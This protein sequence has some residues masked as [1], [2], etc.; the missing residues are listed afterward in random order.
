MKEPERHKDDKSRGGRCSTDCSDRDFVGMHG[1]LID[2]F[3]TLQYG[4]ITPELR[5][6][7]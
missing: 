2:V 3:M 4:F 5:R 7:F 6:Y 1:E